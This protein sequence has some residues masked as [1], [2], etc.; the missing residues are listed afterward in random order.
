MSQ[1]LQL[2]NE[3]RI[4]LGQQITDEIKQAEVDRASLIT[5]IVGFRRLMLALDERATADKPWPTSCSLVPPTLKQSKNRLLADHVPAL[6]GA[7]PIFHLEGDGQQD[8]A[9][10]NEGEQFFDRQLTKQMKFKRAMHSIFDASFVD[11]VGVGVV[12]WREEWRPVRQYQETTEQEIDVETGE[13]YGEPVT[14]RRAKKIL[15]IIYDGPV[16]IPMPIERVGTYPAANS[17][18]QRSPGV[19]FEW[20]MTRADLEQARQARTFDDAML[21][22]LYKI[23][24]EGDYPQTP[25]DVDRNIKSKMTS[26]AKGIAQGWWISECYWL[27]QVVEKQPP[28][29]WRIFL[30][31]GTSL[32]IG[33]EPSPWFSDDVPVFCCRPF[34]DKYGIYADSV[35]DL[36][37]D[38][39]KAQAAL[40]QQ[41]IDAAAMAVNPKILT[42]ETLGKKDV[43]E[44]KKKA[45]PGS[46]VRLTEEAIKNYKKEPGGTLPTVLLPM[47]EQVTKIGQLVLG[48]DDTSLAIAPPPSTTATA[49]SDM[50]DSRAKLTTL[51]AEGLVEGMIECAEIIW[52]MDYQ[53]QAHESLQKLYADANPE[54]QSALQDVLEGKYSFVVSGAAGGGNKALRARRSQERFALLSQDPVVQNNP[55]LKYQALFDVLKDSG[56]RDPEIYIGRKEDY[57]NSMMQMAQA[58]AERQAQEQIAGEQQAKQITQRGRK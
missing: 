46:L 27:R 34:A 54:A 41:T 28:E 2:E 53:F 37:G 32:I 58:E 24:P 10:Q 25:S 20:F 45:G 55:A 22:E 29:R 39:Q 38:V 13:A 15:Q 21:A 31:K 3:T 33:A 11:G 6:L 8:K 17:D 7:E 16:V 18:F 43:D 40:L 23:S 1:A 5:A 57:I 50:M 44:L 51:Q 30:H 14:K 12:S 26:P 49:T 4:D 35:A 47:W 48:V 9:M 52:D 36:A 19:Y 42:G 56:D